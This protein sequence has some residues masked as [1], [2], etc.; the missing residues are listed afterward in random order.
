M[1]APNLNE[2]PPRS[3]RVKLGGFTILPRILD[4]IRAM[5]TDQLGEYRY[6]TPTD[7]QFFRFAGIDPDELVERVKSA[8]GDWEVLEWVRQS[9]TP[10]TP[11]EIEQWARWTE[12]IAFHDVEMREWFTGEIKRLNPARDDVR[13]V[14]DRLDLDDFVSFGGKA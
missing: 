9:G 3:P 4:K 2:R 14:F 13:G 7:Q 5:L 8:A 10:R 11:W 12:T 1:N 6:N